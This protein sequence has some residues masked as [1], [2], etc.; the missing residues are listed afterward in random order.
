M[1]KLVF[2][3]KNRRKLEEA[4]RILRAV[5]GEDY[6]LL[7]PEDLGFDEE[8]EENGQSF[9]ENA[10]C[11]ADAVYLALRLPTIADDSGLCV[12]ALGGAPGIHSA[13]FAGGHGQD[14]ANI[15]KLLAALSNCDDRRA[16][17]VCAVAFR[18]EFHRFCV[19]GECVGDI[20]LAPRGESGF[21]YD[22]VFYYPPYDRSFA[23]LSAEEKDRVSHRYAALVALCDQLKG[24]RL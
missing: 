3:T 9:E 6:T 15:E 14:R 17:F 18:S 21:G 4:Q 8:I 5:S 19:R 13:R 11:K 23:Q 10:L 20:L 2:A 12:D 16:A 22:P 24:K 7:L 1:T